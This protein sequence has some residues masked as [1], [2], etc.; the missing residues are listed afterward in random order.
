MPHI[1]KMVQSFKS[2]YPDWSGVPL[3]TP[4]S[5]GFMLDILDKATPEDSGKFISHKASLIKVSVVRNTVDKGLSRFSWR[6]GEQRVALMASG[7]MVFCS[8]VGL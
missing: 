7:F 4:E 3:E 5:V 6:A 2:V 8:I 1:V